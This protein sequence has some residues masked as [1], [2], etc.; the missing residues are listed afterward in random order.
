MERS[1]YS[2]KCFIAVY[3]NCSMADVEIPS[4]N[5][6]YPYCSKCEIGLGFKRKREK[7][8]KFDGEEHQKKKAKKA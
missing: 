7:G 1:Y 6:T 3:F 4:N 5:D 2:A 8:L